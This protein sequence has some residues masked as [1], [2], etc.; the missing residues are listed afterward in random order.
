MVDEVVTDTRFKNMQYRITD[1]LDVTSHALTTTD[2][3]QVLKMNE[4]Y[5]FANA[6]KYEGAIAIDTN[7]LSLLHH[8]AST[9]PRRQQLCIFSTVQDARKW[10][11]HPGV[12]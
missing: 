8:W 11:N 9:S 6:R 2:I 3:S 1:C 7:V 4:A 5:S 10:L 12:V